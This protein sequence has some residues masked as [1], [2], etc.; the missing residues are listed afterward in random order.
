MCKT[1]VGLVGVHG[2]NVPYRA[3]KVSS[4]GNANVYTPVHQIVQ[5]VMA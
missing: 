2:V 3:I 4:Q 1:N 5:D